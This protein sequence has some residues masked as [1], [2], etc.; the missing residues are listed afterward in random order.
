MTSNRRPSAP[1]AGTSAKTF[2]R[3][4]SARSR[5]PS[6]S[7]SPRSARTRRGSRST[8]TT[9]RAPRRKASIP[10]PPVPAKRSSTS[11]PASRG[12]RAFPTAVLTRPDVGR[13]PPGRPACRGVLPPVATGGPMWSAHLGVLGRSRPEPGPERQG[14]A[15][16]LGTP[17]GGILRHDAEGLLPRP[18]D[19]PVVPQEVGHPEVADAVLAPPAQE[20]AHAP[21]LQVALGDLEPVRRLHHDPQARPRL[22]ASPGRRAAPRKQEDLLGPRSPGPRGWWSWAKPKG[23]ASS[24]TITVAF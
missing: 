20:L 8:N 7:S 2:P 11:A 21:Q 9:C 6:L 18:L 24:M 16:V 17:E 4:T 19:P 1:S 10:S 3:R 5:S 13:S 15:P 14:Q 12:A 22:R 23:A